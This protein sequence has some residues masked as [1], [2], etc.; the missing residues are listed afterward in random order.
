MNCIKE[1]INPDTADAQTV[2]KNPVMYFPLVTLLGPE[3]SSVW[4]T[5][6]VEVV[7]RTRELTMNGVNFWELRKKEKK[8]LKAS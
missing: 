6:G 2:H 1:S 7:R 5:R 3:E 8:A 4:N